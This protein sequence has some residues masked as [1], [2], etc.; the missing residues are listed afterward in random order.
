MKADRPAGAVWLDLDQPSLDRAY[1]Q[2]QWAPNMAQVLQRYA[3]ASERARLELGAPTR[4]AYG[5]TEIE[6]LDFFDCGRAGAPV[7]VFF[8]GGAWRSGKARDYA[9]LAGL[10][11]RA[12]VHVVLPDFSWVQD[13]GGDLRPMA[14]Q[15]RRALTWVHAHASGLGGDPQRLFVSGH[16]SGAHLAAVLATTDWAAQGLPADLIQGT[17]LCSGVYEL[18]PVRRSSRNR[19]V[20]IDDA[21]VQDLSPLRHLAPARGPMVVAWGTRESPEFQRQGA[22]FAGAAAAAGLTATALRVPD[23][24]HFEVLETMGRAGEP[25]AAAALALMRQG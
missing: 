8:H 19:Y 1:D 12:G 6:A 18:E 4:L 17:V 13:C 7:H 11:V 21:A 2:A 5:A 9:F 14:A 3:D 15:A 22:E 20:T 16:S 23:T 25:L 24:N 10:F